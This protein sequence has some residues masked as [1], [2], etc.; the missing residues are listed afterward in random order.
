M[1]NEKKT[2]HY[3]S[4][5]NCELNLPRPM[6]EEEIEHLVGAINQFDEKFFVIHKFAPTKGVP[7]FAYQLYVSGQTDGAAL[8]FQINLKNA[9]AQIV[10][11]DETPGNLRYS[12]QL[13]R[14]SPEGEI[15]AENEY[16]V[17]DRYICFSEREITTTGG[18]SCTPARP[19]KCFPWEGIDNMWLIAK[20]PELLDKYMEIFFKRMSF[21]EITARLEKELYERKRIV[22]HL[23]GEPTEFEEFMNTVASHDCRVEEELPEE[24]DVQPDFATKESLI[25]AGV[26]IP[27]WALGVITNTFGEA[28]FVGLVTEEERKSNP[29]KMFCDR[30]GDFIYNKEEVISGITLWPERDAE[31]L[32]RF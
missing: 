5:T 17:N 14:F 12:Q 9:L 8:N 16:R 1:S 11:L 20:T 24:Q 27:E 7:F 21:F 19:L 30:I 3:D 4:R 6:S 31:I 22:N 23:L 15:P 32:S 28:R 25:E 13:L 10:I 2:I 18:C 29:D 26:E